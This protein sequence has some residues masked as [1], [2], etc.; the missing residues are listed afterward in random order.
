MTDT[1]KLP[2]LPVRLPL[3]KEIVR[4]LIPK[5]ATGDV[6]DIG[7]GTAKYKSFILEHVKSYK[8]S[9]VEGGPNIDLVEDALNL[10]H[11]DESFNTVISFQT[12]EHLPD[13]NRM[14]SELRRVLKKG[15][16]C[17]VTV[18]F[19]MA[20]HSCPEDYR[21]F[22]RKGAR[23]LFEHAGFTIVELNGYGST[24]SVLAEFLKFYFIHPWLGRSYSK[25]RRMLVVYL[26][27]FLYSLDRRGW[28]ANP[29]FY[30]NVYIVAQKPAHP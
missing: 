8:A 7:A 19:F 14:V 9:D 26:M 15:G 6:L 11:A 18:P 23:D 16:N 12:L 29:H 17:I 13:P 3:T 10:S 30:P 22:S 1:R 27:N 21:R 2:E 25:P 28:G 24:Y 4:Y 20:E 5:Y